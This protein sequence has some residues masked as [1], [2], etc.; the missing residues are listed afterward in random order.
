[1]DAQVQGKL[2]RNLSL[3]C[4]GMKKKRELGHLVEGGCLSEEQKINFF[5]K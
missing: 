4:H 1:M 5:F 3:L 2:K